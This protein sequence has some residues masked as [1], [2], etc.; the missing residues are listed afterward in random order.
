MTQE[1]SKEPVPEV[2]VAEADLDTFTA[3]KETL[4]DY[5]L[6][7]A[8][9]SYRKWSTRVVG[10]SALGGIAYP[11]GL[12]DR[13]Q[14]RH[15]LRNRARAVGHRDFRGGDLPDRF[16]G[17]LLRRALQHRPGPDHPWQ[18]VRLLR[19][20]GHQRH[21]RDVHLHLLCAR[22]LHHGPRTETGTRHPAVAGLRNVN[23]DYLPAANLME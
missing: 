10:I 8:P 16:P 13:R 18:R 2:D 11:G 14:Y 1:L 15:L 23:T 12:R 22:R 3:T 4:E 21:L 5:T 7:F 6:R 17:G 20:G 19:F 9:R